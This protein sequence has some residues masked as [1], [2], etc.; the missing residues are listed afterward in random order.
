MKVLSNY[1]LKELIS[2]I[3]LSLVIFILVI[4]IGNIVKLGG[5][6]ITK[7][8]GIV[9]VGKLFFFLLL[10]PLN[11][12]IPLAT[13]TGTLLAFG[14]LSSDNE[15]TALK[16]I[17]FNLY[18]LMIPAIIIGLILSFFSIMLND[19]LIPDMHFA[20]R[21]LLFE[22]GMKKPAA[23]LEE[24]TFVK[25]F[26]DYIIFIHEI[27]GN[28]LKGV[29]I[30]QPQK[31]RPTRT[32][33]AERG[34][35]IPM[36]EKKMIALKLINGSSDEPNAEDPTSFYKLNF[37]T[38]YLTLNLQDQLSGKDIE[39]KAK[40][41][42]F[43]ELIKKIKDPAC[44]PKSLLLSKIEFHKKI[45]LSFASLVFV[46]IG[47]PLALLAKREE[48]FIGFGLGLAVFI[49]YY[50]LLSTG[51]ALV[52]QGVFPPAVSMWF[53]DILIATAGIM[54]FWLAVEK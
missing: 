45:S 30:Y 39:K 41:M 25:A 24:G 2:S 12:I 19:R 26:D 38:Y 13:L 28:K 50:L 48:K 53:P 52:L 15:I 22:I 10:K 37:K 47:L 17:G 16:A 7:G 27:D 23:C 20:I 54:L 14:R 51:K 36:S 3:I 42:A 8:I 21:K 32:I 44:S 43:R 18:K 35:L 31:G 29:R 33:T 5:L 34:E 9:Y 1:V 11:Y 49:I 4:F 40:D 6:I 46:M